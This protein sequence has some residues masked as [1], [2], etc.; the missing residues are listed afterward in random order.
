MLKKIF[1]SVLV[2]IASHSASFSFPVTVVDESGSRFTAIS[3][4]RRIISTMPSNTEILFDLGLGDRI[5]GVT[6]RCDFPK[7]AT[8]K[9]KI[10]DINLDLEEII[11]LNPDLVVMLGSAQKYQIEKMRSHSLPV[12]VIDP[13]NMDQ[14]LGSIDLLGK[15][16]G[17]SKK[18]E[19]TIT[20]MKKRIKAATVTRNAASLPKVLV[21]LWANPL[22]TAGKGTFIDDIVSRSGAVNIGAGAGGQYP[23][24]SFE[25]VLAQD[26]DFIIVAGK[27]YGDIRSITDDRKWDAVKAV[28]DKKIL[29]ID[30]DIIT[31]P[32]PRIVK[33]MELISKFING[34]I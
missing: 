3:A 28:K 9:R 18:A 4:P 34:K 15:I 5:V 8:K 20:D 19:A 2:I 6:S 22:T 14:L 13:R 33:A 25:T 31:R 11:S 29:L 10:G 24:I 16:T 32:S 12:F 30:S 26:P 23:T 17:T 1:L 21:V 7:A 27:S